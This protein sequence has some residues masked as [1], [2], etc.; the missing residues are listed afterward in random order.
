[1]SVKDLSGREEPYFSMPYNIIGFRRIVNSPNAR[2]SHLLRARLDAKRTAIANAKCDSDLQ[3]VQYLSSGLFQ[4][5]LYSPLRPSASPWLS[6]FYDL[7]LGYS[8]SHYDSLRPTGKSIIGRTKWFP[9][10]KS[11]L[12]FPT[13]TIPGAVV[14]PCRRWRGRRRRWR[15]KTKLG[16]TRDV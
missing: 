1:M 14:S 13:R 8:S 6:S 9:R 10:F 15:H 16:K 5:L 7:C 3:E 4:L 2:C 11:H 12:S